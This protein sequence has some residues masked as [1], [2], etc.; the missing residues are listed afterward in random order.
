MNYV[1]IGCPPVVTVTPSSGPFVVGD[2]LTC[3]SDSTLSSYSFT[4]SS[5][6]VTAGNTV[7][8]SVGSFVY[9]CTAA[10][11]ID[12]PCS[13]SFSVTGTAISKKHTRRIILIL[14]VKYIHFKT[15]CKVMP[16]KQQRSLCYVTR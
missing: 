3:T 14:T 8:L 2:V 16:I 11:D 10:I 4:D 9:T 1:C 12:V 7:T 5:G 13:A 15:Q 6:T